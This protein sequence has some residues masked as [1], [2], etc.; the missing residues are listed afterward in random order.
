MGQSAHSR[1][2]KHSVDVKQIAVEKPWWNV[3][4][5]G[6]IPVESLAINGNLMGE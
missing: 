1:G 5:S 4:F 2:K 3:E 6:S